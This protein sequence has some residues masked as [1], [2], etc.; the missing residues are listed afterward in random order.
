VPQ[1]SPAREPIPAPS[2]PSSRQRPYLAAALVAAGL[3]LTGVAHAEP[4]AEERALA[5]TLF[6]DAR[7]LMKDGHVPE[8]CRK[9]EESERLDPGGGTLLNVA[10]C[11]EAEGRTASAWSEFTEALRLARSAA[12]EDRVRLAEERLAVLEPHLSTLVIEVPAAADLPDLEVRRDG[13]LV[14]RAAWGGA[15]PVDPGEHVVVASAVGKAPQWFTASVPAG[16]GVT[17]VTLAP[18]RDEEPSAGGLSA[19]AMPAA[20]TPAPGDAPHD[21]ASTSPA[22]EA[23]RTQRVAALSV[24]AVGAAGLVAGG[25]FG[26]LALSEQHR[27]N[28]DSGAKVCTSEAAYATNQDSVRHGTY[29][30][31]GFVGGG[32]A[33]V[34]GAILWFTA[35]R[36]PSAVPARSSVAVLPSL[37]SRGGGGGGVSIVGHW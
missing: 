36:A 34:A 29:A 15:M 21:S 35:P 16:P 1:T 25:V 24:A 18:L 2:C 6:R 14:G 37:D 7:A 8:A 22:P 20:I 12:R 13:S 31:V 4:T 11:H 10:V 32:A 9:F 3:S 26:A 28:C 33:V 23:G 19:A 17:K 5:T 30:T 27:A